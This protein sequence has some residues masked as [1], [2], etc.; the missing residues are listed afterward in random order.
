MSHSAQEEF[1]ALNTRTTTAQTHPEDA[2]DNSSNAS[3]SSSDNESSG[4]HSSDG[5]DSDIASP[6][7]SSTMPSAVYTLPTTAFAAN[8]G[9]KGVIADAQSFEKARK[10][11]FR[12]TLYAFSNNLGFGNGEKRPHGSREKSPSGDSS[13]DEDDKEFMR[14]WRT[15]RM[16]EVQTQGHDNR[17]RRSSPSKRRYGHV[18]SVGP[19]GYLDAIEEVSAETIVVVLI[20]DDRV[21]CSTP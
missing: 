12:S 16:N 4:V 8:T 5:N 21:R 14:K 15:E 1:N 6:R 9:P 13:T 7:T 2:L 3:D 17:T 20:N 10:R 18:A 11:S 19:I